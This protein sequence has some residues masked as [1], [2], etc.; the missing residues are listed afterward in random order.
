MDTTTKSIRERR[1]RRRENWRIAQQFKPRKPR[2][3]EDYL[4]YL[5]GLYSEH[6]SAMR[7]ERMISRHYGF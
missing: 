4:D 2:Y 3:D 6:A 5:E 1:E 7:K